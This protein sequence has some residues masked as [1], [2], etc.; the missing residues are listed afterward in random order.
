MCDARYAYDAILIIRE[1]LSLNYQQFTFHCVIKCPILRKVFHDSHLEHAS[2]IFLFPHSLEHQ[3]FRNG[4][5]GAA[6][7]VSGGEEGFDNMR[8]CEA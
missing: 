6:D 5:Y 7:F 1:M 8:A 4:A 2:A 3:Y